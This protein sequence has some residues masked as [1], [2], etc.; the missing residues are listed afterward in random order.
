ML[1]FWYNILT[2]FVSLWRFLY[3][4]LAVLKFA[5]YWLALNSQTDLSASAFQVLGIEAYTTRPGHA[6]SFFGKVSISILGW[7]ET[8][9]VE[10]VAFKR[11][12]SS[13]LPPSAE[14]KGVCHHT[15]QRTFLY[16]YNMLCF[17]IWLCF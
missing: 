4:S 9:C 17:E 10:Q 8:C 6:F 14:L 12:D 11:K 13:T 16:D 3:I 2:F 7:L 5:L 15:W 1:I